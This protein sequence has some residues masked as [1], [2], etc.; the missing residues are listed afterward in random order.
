MVDECFNCGISG[1]R[2]RFFDA[3]SGKGIVKIC[4]ECASKENIPIVRKPSEILTPTSYRDLHKGKTVYERLSRMSGFDLKNK[5]SETEKEFLQK[6]ETTLK[7]IIDKNF[8]TQFKEKLKPR[9]D[10][11]H[12]FHWVIMRVRRSKHITQEQLA[13]EIAEPEASIKMA[14]QGI[15]PKDSYKLIN[16]LENYLAIKLIKKEFAD[17]IEEKPKEIGFDSVTTKSLTISDLKEMKEKKEAEILEEPIPFPED[18]EDVEDVGEIEDFGN[19][20]EKED[21]SQEEKDLLF[22]E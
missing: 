20:T 17:K 9:S 22:G 2:I 1:E 16:K 6:Q 7:D 11:I 15:L 12:N 13:K 3:I 4:E 19:E 8:K 18:V 5:K 21:L 10:L 14:E